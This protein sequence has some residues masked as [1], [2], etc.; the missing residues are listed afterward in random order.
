MKHIYGYMNWDDVKEHI[1]NNSIVIIPTGAIESHGPHM[2]TDTDTHQAEYISNLVA[3]RVGGVAVPPIVYGVSKTFEHFPGT[4][5]LSIP[6][7]QQVL[8]EVASALI[9]QGFVN[10]VILNGNR[11]NG[12]SNDAV[13]RRLIDDLD[14]KYDFKV[15]VINLWEPAAPKIQELRNSGPGGIGHGGEMETSLQL[16]IRPELVHVDRLSTVPKP[17][18]VVWDAIAGPLP[19]YTY[20]RRPNPDTNPSSIFGDPS[21]ASAETGEAFLKAIVDSLV[22]VIEN[23]QV[24]YQQRKS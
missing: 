23:L 2:P 22:D 21:V 24:A 7:Y 5:S 9:K 1:E 17:P 12:T 4:I 16:A 8:Y 10:I 6:T 20:A 14:D 15:T 11:P 3:E 19:A 18:M 13:A